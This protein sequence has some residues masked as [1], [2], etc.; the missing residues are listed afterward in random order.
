MQKSTNQTDQNENG[1]EQ[2][3]GKSKGKADK[4]SVSFLIV[5]IDFRFLLCE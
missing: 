1:E 5:I 2:A 4:T 3:N